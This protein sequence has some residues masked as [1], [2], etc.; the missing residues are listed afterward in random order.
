[1]TSRKALRI[2]ALAIPLL[3]IASIPTRTALCQG[4][5]DDINLGD[6]VGASGFGLLFSRAAD[7]THWLS[8]SEEYH[9]DVWPVPK[10]WAVGVS[11]GR[12]VQKELLVSP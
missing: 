7:A 11:E 5:F 1:M 4:R 12:V 8:S 3:A 6:V 9:C 2:F 10:V